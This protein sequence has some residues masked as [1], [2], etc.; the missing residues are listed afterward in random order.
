MKEWKSQV[1]RFRSYT[2]VTVITNTEKVQEIHYLN[3]RRIYLL[4]VCAFS[5]TYTSLLRLIDSTIIACKIQL[6]VSYGVSSRFVARM[7]EPS[8]Y[9]YCTCI[10]MSS[11]KFRACDFCHIIFS[12]AMPERLFLHLVSWF[13]ESSGPALSVCL[14]EEECVWILYSAYLYQGGKK[15]NSWLLEVSGFSCN[16][17]KRGRYWDIFCHDIWLKA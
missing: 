17:T 12:A 7:L 10:C 4:V 15:G 9:P 16:T 14:I 6:W 1:I 8:N 11:V 3:I 5:Y 2:K 13:P